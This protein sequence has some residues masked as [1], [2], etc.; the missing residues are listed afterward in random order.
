MNM[1][2]RKRRRRGSFVGKMMRCLIILLAVTA[3]VMY[4]CQK[5]VRR[6]IAETVV[7]HAVKE[8]IQYAG[9]E[10]P[11]IQQAIDSLTPE[12]KEAVTEIVENNI[13]PDKV[14]AVNNYLQSGDYQGL[15]T[16][17]QQNLTPEEYSRLEQIY[18]NY[19]GQP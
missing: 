18:A 9:A 2:G 7:D 10:H 16:Y 4:F 6:L 5:P 13:T 11:E 17:A 3:G 15:I 19:A 12:D 14:A 1:S 8:S